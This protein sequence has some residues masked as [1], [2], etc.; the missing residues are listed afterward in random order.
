[1]VA[2]AMG[3]QP[4]FRHLSLRPSDADDAVIRTEVEMARKG[5]AGRIVYALVVSVC[6]LFWLAPAIVAAYAAVVV[7]WETIGRPWSTA[8]VVAALRDR[9]D[10]LRLYHRCVILSVACL[11]AL[12]PFTGVFSHLMIG[13]YVAIMSFC[14]AIIAGVTYFSNDKWQ[15]AACTTP[16]FLVAT[17]APFTFGVPLP[18]VTVVLALNAMFVLSALQSA[19]HRAELVESIT[20]EEAARSR[21]ENANVE[22]SQFIANVS[23]ELRTPL[24]AIIGYTELM[25]ENAE[26]DSRAE[27]QADLDKV[28][29]AS[30]RLLS[31]VNELL[32][33]SK[34]EAGKLAL[35]VSWY[36]ASEMIGAAADIVRPIAEANGNTLHLELAPGLGQGVSDEFRL[37]QCVVNLLTNAA[38]F[39]ENG[40]V[41]LRA[42]RERGPGGEWFVIDVGDTGIGMTAETLERV[43]NPFT[44]ADA[45]VTR[46]Y[47]GTG[48][49]LAITRR[50]ARLLGGDVTV[51]S[52][53]G[54]GSTFTLRTPVVARISGELEAAA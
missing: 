13:W 8:R 11:Y 3:W 25:R 43:F 4:V 24:N 47:G 40:A 32:D 7:L 53:P 48:L 31:M 22:K 19:L 30:R 35:E 14:S 20:K 26:E 39:T 36:D 2:A 44:Q 54:A 28:L 15:F 6:A 18:I 29:A 1:M 16:S 27:D 23:H 49:G 17:L 33:I 12:I 38:R 50:V 10:L 52:E 41:T 51:V 5:V 9:R 42:R 34:I 45:S 37:S 21:A 46:K